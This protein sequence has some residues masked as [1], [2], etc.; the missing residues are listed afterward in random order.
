MSGPSEPPG[1]TD[2]PVL[3][4]RDGAVAFLTLNRPAAA[5]TIDAPLANAFLEAVTALQGAAEVRALVIRGAGPRFCGGG[6]LV[7]FSR[8]DAQASAYVDGLIHDLHAA[9]VILAEFHAPIITA[10]HGAAAGGGLGLALAGDL[11]LASQSCRFVMAYTRAGLTPDG[12]TSWLLPRL[13][14]AR[15][16][17]DLTF[18]NRTLDAGEALALGLISEVTADDALAGRAEALARQLAEGPTAA[19]ATARGLLRGASP[20]EFAAH[21]EREAASIVQS[22]RTADGLE[23]VRAFHE[24]RPPAFRG[25]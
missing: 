9:L 14:G 18:L 16:A 10:V 19:F 21:L 5:N 24:H 22:F 3:T 12:G 17:L 4:H 2:S 13:V 25:T 11:V 6:D 1:E 7:S 20:A 23:G 15:R 8:Q